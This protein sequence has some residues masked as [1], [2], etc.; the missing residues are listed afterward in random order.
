M[1]KN[2][3][4]IAIG[5]VL[6][7]GFCV[8]LY[9]IVSDI[10]ARMTQSITIS[11]YKKAVENLSSEDILKLKAEA[12]KYNESL[13]GVHLSDPFTND[14]KVDASNVPLLSVDDVM[15]YIEIPKINVYLPI[16]HDSSEEVL[17]KGVGHLENTSLPIGGESTHTVL[18]GHRGLPSATLFTDLDQL[19]R[20]DV[21]YLH[22]LD[23]D[24][25]Y[26]VDQIKVVEPYDT[27]D[28]TIVQGKDYVTL[29]TCTP[30]GI[31]TQRL[32]I[33]GERIPF[34]AEKEHFQMRM[35]MVSEVVIV[36]SALL[37]I[38]TVPIV[39]IFLRKIKGRN[40]KNKKYKP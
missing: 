16:Y 36:P 24:L 2:L 25:A 40:E 35:D 5:C 4:I 34:V 29:V 7:I 31:N 28:L 9:P 30:Y 14:E 39:L 33:R 26:K 38:I 3:P 27:E 6:L 11:S 8:L 22:V 21:F 18:T 32:L 15:G 20:G 12:Q 23:E 19:T 37:I 13:Y 1:K 10:M 17:Q